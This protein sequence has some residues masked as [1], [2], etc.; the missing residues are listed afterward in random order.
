VAEILP[1]ETV[2]AGYRIDGLL[3]VGGMGVVYEATQLS[4]DRKVALKIVASG[5]STDPAFRVRF[6]REGL[7]QARLE[8]PNIV[9][10]YEAGDDDG[11]LFLAMRLVR[12]P[13]L[14]DMLCAELLE[15]ARALRIL[16][17]VANALDHAHGA[18][19]IHRDVK[20]HNILV[21]KDD[22]PY[23]ADFGI[24]KGVSDTA[25]TRTGQFMG[26]SDYI[27]PEQ[28]KGE[29]V[30]AACDIYALGA[31][32]YECLSG[33]V[34][35]DKELDTAVLYA[36]VAEL[37][38]KLS[39]H[40]AHL[41]ETLDAVIARGMAKE[42][43]ERPS[44]AAE[45][46]EAAEQCFEEVANS[47]QLACSSRGRLSHAGK[48]NDA[49][50]RPRRR[51]P[52]RQVALLLS[53]AAIVGVGYTIGH[54]SGAGG[55][56]TRRTLADGV[57]SIALSSDW[58][59]STAPTVPGLSI[60]RPVA[61]RRRNG[62]VLA[63][64]ILDD[65][66][67]RYLLPTS[68]EKKLETKQNPDPVQLRTSVAYRYRQLRVRGFAKPLAL[69]LV[70]TTAGAV[71]LVC[72]AATSTCEAAAETMRLSDASPLPLGPNPHYAE[73]LAVAI[74]KAQS[75]AALELALE[76]ARTRAGQSRL[77]SALAGVYIA[78]A[79]LLAKA[80]PGPDATRFNASLLD[81]LEMTA[82]EY[83]RM[84]GA[85]RG[86]ESDRFHEAA[87]RRLGSQRSIASI[88]ASLSSSGYG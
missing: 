60:S 7:I 12:G 59:R 3:G 49:P 66:E 72:V 88:L 14:K 45:L 62:D 31:V 53:A 2:V 8:H 47:E 65:A 63:L 76:R 79:G 38:P 21:D 36:H 24:T 29:V 82:R 81:A 4:L 15:P 71:A 30:T 86:G 37:P 52:T 13:S 51:S 67:G 75:A 61:A 57:A 27:A 74:S 40:R 35:F 50:S 19:L 69:I 39:E 64:G 78:A 20:P 22:Y 54:S 26:S 46:V 5:L 18:G 28:I 55:A 43:R 42:P 84:A 80:N 77:S 48:A 58:M 17:A 16:H 68:F 6:R 73:A 83:S 56:G 23:L 33:V 11:L 10:V 9:T 1:P 85:A 34:P 32:L 25:L 41:P 70:P 87:V 44:T